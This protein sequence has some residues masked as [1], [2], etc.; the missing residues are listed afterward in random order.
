MMD[1]TLITA[2]RQANQARKTGVPVIGNDWRG[3]LDD[4]F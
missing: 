3:E 4:A 1:K 2:K